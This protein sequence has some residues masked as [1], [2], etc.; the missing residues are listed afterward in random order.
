MRRSRGKAT[1]KT[2]A[3][4]RVSKM[5]QKDTD[6]TRSNNHS[7]IGHCKDVQRIMVQLVYQKSQAAVQ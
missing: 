5:V 4:L 2:G 7:S 1:G 6:I 3:E